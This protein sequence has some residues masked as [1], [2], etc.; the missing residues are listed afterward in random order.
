VHTD[1]RCCIA[2]LVDA[3][4]QLGSVEEAYPH[5]Y[6][7]TPMASAPAAPSL[8][9]G[10]AWPP[11]EQVE[12]PAAL[13]CEPGDP[14]VIV[15]IVDTGIARRHPALRLRAGWD[16]V[17]LSPRDFVGSVEILGDRVEPDDDP[18]DD[19]VGH[20]TACAGII[21]ARG[22]G[23]PPGLAGECGVL[24]IRALGS[25]RFPGHPE[26]IGVGSISDIDAGIKMAMDLGA[27]VLNLSLGTAA[28]A[29]GEGDPECHADVVRYGLAKGC[30]MVAA[31]GNTGTAQ[32]FLPAALDGVIAVGS[33]SPEGRP[34]AFSTSGEHVALLAP[35][36]RVLTTGRGGYQKVTG[37]SFAAPFVAGA[38][39]LLVSRAMR[40]SFPLDGR[41]VSRLLC[42]SARPLP[43]GTPTGHGRGVLDAHA[44]LRRLEREIAQRATAHTSLREPASEGEIA[45]SAPGA[46]GPR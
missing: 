29:L 5:Y 22:E 1:R 32:R 33:A 37:T 26:P 43:A 27:K 41:D 3:L 9:L 11:H 13:A 35:G 46:T 25:A 15:A 23:L 12:G 34:S 36:E 6:C 28:S 8:D 16:T 31:S 17:Q 7:T 45:G 30:V 24:P 38:A 44:A 40:Q 18:D 2:D 14:A 39:A 42:E 19:V 4:R 20:G 21:G 10:Q